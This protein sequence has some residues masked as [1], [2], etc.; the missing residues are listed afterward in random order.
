MLREERRTPA[1]K[2][3][4]KAKKERKKLLN[5]LGFKNEIR[6]SAP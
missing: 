1:M 3:R 4:R 5:L 6:Y 2:N